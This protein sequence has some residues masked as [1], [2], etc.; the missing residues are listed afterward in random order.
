M[1]WTP[2]RKRAL[3]RPERQAPASTARAPA[4]PA[5][6]TRIPSK[7]RR[8]VRR[9]Q[10]QPTRHACAE[11]SRCACLRAPLK[12][13]AGVILSREKA[14]GKREKGEREKAKLLLR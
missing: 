1:P 4:E 8:K 11:I 5:R 13:G 6:S 14:K 7:P 3:W 12:R 2:A 10:G 9:P